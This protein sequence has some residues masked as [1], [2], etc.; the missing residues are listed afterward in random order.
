MFCISLLSSSVI[1]QLLTQCR[2]YTLLASPKVL[3][4][5]EVSPVIE[6]NLL[7]FEARVKAHQ[8]RITEAI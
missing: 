8:A 3:M 5:P 7:L 6:G 2:E 1:A 4:S